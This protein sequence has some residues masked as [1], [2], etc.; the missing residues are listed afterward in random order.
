M[1][2]YDIK[3]EG[4]DAETHVEIDLTDDEAALLER[5]AHATRQASE[6]DCQPKMT[7]TPMSFY[8]SS[9]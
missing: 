6:Y 4:C 8:R 1:A 3:L 7:L 5:V 2:A 9:T